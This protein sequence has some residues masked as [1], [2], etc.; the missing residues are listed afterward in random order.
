MD[1]TD[2]LQ[3]IRQSTEERT[4]VLHLR[5]FAN[6]LESST[7]ERAALAAAGTA[8]MLDVESK[9]AKEIGEAVQAIPRDYRS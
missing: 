7:I 3:R 1:L 6:S 8:V 9:V 4:A 5:C 2:L